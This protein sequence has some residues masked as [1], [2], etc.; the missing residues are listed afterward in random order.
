MELLTPTIKHMNEI[1][2]IKDQNRGKPDY[3]QTQAVADGADVFGWVTRENKQWKQAEES[4][5]ATQFYG[6]KVIQ[7]Y[8]EQ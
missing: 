6:N 4:L 3:N 2:S 5:Q 8:K 1:G 7:Q